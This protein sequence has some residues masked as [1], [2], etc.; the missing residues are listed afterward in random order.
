MT[1]ATSLRLTLSVLLPLAGCALDSEGTSPLEP[2]SGG[3]DAG[4]MDAASSLSDAAEPSTNADGEGGLPLDARV[5]AQADAHADAAPG[6]A[7]GLL[8]TVRDFTEAHPDFEKYYGLW[9]DTGIVAEQLGLDRKPVYA[10]STRTL[11]TSGGAEFAQW[12]RD[13]PGVNMRL[14]TTLRFAR[15]QLGEYVFSSTAFFPIDGQGFGN[16]PSSLAG[17]EPAHNYLFT[18]EA[19]IRFTYRGGETLTF[20][21][22]DDVW[23]FVNDLLAVN[24]GGVH[25]QLTRTISLDEL[26][27]QLE[28]ERGK[29]YPL[30]IFHAERHTTD[31]NYRIE[32]TIDLSCIENVWVP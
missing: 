25:S 7:D 32:T 11:T 19:H 14:H 12:Y 10:T 23:I 20:L 18:T 3:V 2:V 1:A 6:C 29:S 24:L 26:A 15:D 8:L 31:S 28:I 30:D 22:D 21:G 27:E 4:G 5:D 16:G 9:A 13:T 17:V